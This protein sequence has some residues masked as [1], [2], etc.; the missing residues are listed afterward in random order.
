MHMFQQN[1]KKN[2]SNRVE[3]PARHGPKKS[4]FPANDPFSAATDTDTT[5]N[6]HTSEIT[7]SD[8]AGDATR[9]QPGPF[10]PPSPR[11]A[12]RA[13]RPTSHV[14]RTGEREPHPNHQFADR[15]GLFDRLGTC[16]TDRTGLDWTKG[17]GTM[18]MG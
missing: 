11:P 17:A 9:M 14:P 10:G 7:E 12:P 6:R 8:A 16:D 2:Q 15:S 13:P 4:S 5:Y 1:Q 3:Q 18:T